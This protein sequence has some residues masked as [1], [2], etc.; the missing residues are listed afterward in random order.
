MKCLKDNRG[1]ALVM[2]MGVITVVSMMGMIAMGV[3]LKNFQN[4][5]KMKQDRA[6]YYT[7]HIYEDKKMPLEPDGDVPNNEQAGDG[8]EI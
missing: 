5:Q 8:D 3:S 4:V 7:E 6:A 1:T 2:V